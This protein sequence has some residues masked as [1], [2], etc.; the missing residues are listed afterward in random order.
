[1]NWFQIKAFVNKIKTDNMNIIKTKNGTSVVIDNS[2]INE[3]YCLDTDTNEVIYYNGN[4]GEQTPSRFKKITHSFPHLSGTTELKTAVTLQNELE[5]WK[6]ME[7]VNGMGKY[8]RQ[9]M[10]D[11]LTNQINELEDEGPEYD[12]A[13]FTEEDRVVNGQYKTN[14]NDNLKK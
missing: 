11:S 3:G 6:V 5:R 8:A 1:M 4:Y 2:P 9:T 7:P 14:E 10:I 12:S 13:G